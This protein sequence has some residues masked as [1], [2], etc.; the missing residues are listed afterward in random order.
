M[1]SS[2]PRP[3]LR[4]LFAAGLFAL[5]AGFAFAASDEPRV[6]RVA[7]DPNNLPFSNARGE[8]FENRLAEL[9]A[10]ELGARLDY[11]W[12]PQ[13]RGFFRETL[14]SG[15]A[16]LVVGVPD[17]F[18]RVLTTHPYYRSTY[19][20]VAHPGIEPPRSFDD[21]RLPSLKI[22][23]QLIGDDFHNTPPA[24][25]LS[26]RGCIENIRGYTVYGDY[27]KDSPPS[28]IVGATASGEVDV[29]VAWGPMAAYFAHRQSPPLAVAPVSPEQDGPTRP[30]TF[31]IAMG[32]RRGD[33]TLKREIDAVLERRRDE[34]ERILRDYDV[35]LLPLL[36]AKTE[37]P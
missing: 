13:R 7:A 32:V 20:F 14:G 25:A 29:S 12:W 27:A 36:A 5:L 22:G 1:C 28:A 2:F 24:H 16:D 10:R 8:G 4:S 30:F 26:A 34:I 35:P 23:V 15:R 9:V 21:P 6:L 31:A 33:E 3:W 18:E 17:G 19:V 37:A 11:M